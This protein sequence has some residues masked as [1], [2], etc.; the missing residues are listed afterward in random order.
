M[1]K[2]ILIKA[3]LSVL[4]ILTSIFGGLQLTYYFDDVYP[5][6]MPDP[7]D[8]F[9]RFCLAVTR[10]NDLANPDDMEVLALLLYWTI[11]TLLVAALLFICYT[12][13]RRYR[14]PARR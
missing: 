6:N 2:Q 8:R 14:N 5:G 12:V 9:I 10:H 1:K 11:A 7:V 13:V 4:W 3:S